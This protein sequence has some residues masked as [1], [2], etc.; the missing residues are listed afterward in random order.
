M[1]T[2]LLMFACLRSL[3]RGSLNYGLLAFIFAIG[4]GS[5]HG[6]VAMGS[7]GIFGLYIVLYTLYR[8]ET[9]SVGMIS[10]NMVLVAVLMAIFFSIF[11]LISYDLSAGVLEAMTRYQEGSLASVNRADYRNNI[12][13]DTIGQALIGIPIGFFQYLF[14]PIPGRS[15]AIVDLALMAENGLRLLLILTAIR[16]I[17]AADEMH[18][19]LLVLFVFGAYLGSELVWS[20]GT[21]N[22]GTA[23]RHHVASM[24]L[25]ILPFAMRDY[26]WFPKASLAQRRLIPA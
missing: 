25:L 13:G 24:A 5:T 21:I 8:K 6:A 26:Q 22:W 4:A 23:S 17:F 7:A 20:L 2:T 19:R 11:S 16:N 14:E 9:I 15:F 10:I 1:F 3:T 18:K 12:S